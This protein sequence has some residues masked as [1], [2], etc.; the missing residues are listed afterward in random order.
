MKKSKRKKKK[1]KAPAVYPLT[2]T[3]I[4]KIL[5][6]SVKQYKKDIKEIFGEPKNDK[7]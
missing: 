5:G 6:I 2:G 4:L 3:E 1:D 7:R